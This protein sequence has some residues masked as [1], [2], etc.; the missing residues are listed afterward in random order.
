V[1]KRVIP[2]PQK[3]TL[4]TDQFQLYTSMILF[5][6][7]SI[8]A[9]YSTCMPWVNIHFVQV[10]VHSIYLGVTFTTSKDATRRAVEYIISQIFRSI[11]N[12]SY[13]NAFNMNLIAI[14]E[15]RYLIKK[16]IICRYH[17]IAPNTVI[18]RER[19][20]LCVRNDIG[21]HWNDVI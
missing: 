9:L 1:G 2:S 7:G 14:S 17:P 3:L 8:G 21:R 6:V 10:L 19:I 11:N 5:I 13:T 16:L 4:I 18:V 15:V 12:L 20:E